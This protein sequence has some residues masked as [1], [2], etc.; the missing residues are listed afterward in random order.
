[1]LRTGHR[2]QVVCV[3]TQVFLSD[4]H[5]SGV[6]SSKVK[7]VVFGLRVDEQVNGC[8]ECKAITMPELSNGWDT[9]P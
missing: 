1:M 9:P 2:C 6:Q 8:S 3:V 5:H 7:P 4:D